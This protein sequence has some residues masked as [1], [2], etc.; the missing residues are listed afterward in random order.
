MMKKNMQTSMQTSV[1]PPFSG[2]RHD[3][4]RVTT[5][6]KAK[7]LNNR[8]RKRRITL[9]KKVDELRECGAHV[10]LFVEMNNRRYTYSSETSRHFPPT[11]EQIE[12]ESYPLAI[13][14]G[15]NMLPIMG[16]GTED[17]ISSTK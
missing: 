16:G 5:R 17:G 12:N 13:Q 9:F 3:N 8:S 10:Y 1:P 15:P 2:D 7:L 11:L 6:N 14:Y 4:Y